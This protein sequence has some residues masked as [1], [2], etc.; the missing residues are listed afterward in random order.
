MANTAPDNSLGG[1]R[2]LRKV[3][4]GSR[5]D[6]FLGSS[7]TGAVV[8][9]VFR[10]DVTAAS[11]GTELD[12]LGRLAS[13]HLVR[14]LDVTSADDDRPILVLDRVRRG[15]ISALVRDRD[16]LERG[17]VVTILAPL[18]AALPGLH[19]LGIGHG[20]IGARNLHLGSSGEPVL[21]GFGHCALFARD[22]SIAAIDAEPA[23]A[24]DRDDLAS[25]AVA[26]LSRIRGAATDRRV[27]EL[28]EW[29]DAAPREFEFLER[30]ESRLFDLA[31]PLPI[32]LG[33][34]PAEPSAVPARLGLVDH[35][36]P[37][38]ASSAEEDA[39]VEPARNVLA[40]LD[41]VLR[42]NPID[43]VK[44]KVVAAAKGVRKRFWVATG[45]IVLAFVF[46]IALLPQ[47]ASSPTAIPTAMPTGSTATREPVPT[48][49]PLPNDPV[50]A[51]PLLLSERGRCIRDRSVL[52]LDNVDEQ[53]S[54]AYSDDAALIQQLQGGGE[55]SASS[56][57]TAPAPSL[58]EQLGDSAI[59]SLGRPGGSSTSAVAA[60]PAS[61]LMIENQ[62]GWRI[63]GYLTGV[64]ATGS[65]SLSN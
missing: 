28:I 8:L 48:P 43:A 45:A 2:L 13:P 50:L 40:R 39:R 25:L 58:T 33:R 54:S 52:C 56:T 31:D 42:D 19:R 20:R 21:L 22:G 15:S 37:S 23:V 10:A 49:T 36:L 59:L 18:A 46:A 12:A 24:S 35:S 27:T 64:Q 1:F 26:L 55:L 4:A 62:A 61:V 30:L 17:E 53:S 9:K 57:L 41:A 7:E 51:L 65:P 63:R 44:T 34:R 47:N 29:I 38:R 3:G 32:E 5:A 60:G 6:V 14:L 11:I 16:S